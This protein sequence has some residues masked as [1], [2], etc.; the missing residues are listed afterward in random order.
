M[1]LLDPELPILHKVWCFLSLLKIITLEI[2]SLL[3]YVHA[4]IYPQYWEE[5]SAIFNF[6]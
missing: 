1:L 2:K 3:I 4:Q 6:L 5:S